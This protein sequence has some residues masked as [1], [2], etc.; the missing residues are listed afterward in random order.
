MWGCFVEWMVPDV[1]NRY[2]MLQIFVITRSMTQCHIP[3]DL[4][5]QQHH[6]ENFAQDTELI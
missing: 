1:S 2:D 4:N 5:L 3:E 6:C